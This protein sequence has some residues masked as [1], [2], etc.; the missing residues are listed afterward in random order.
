MNLRSLVGPR[1]EAIQ[2][3]IANMPERWRRFLGA[4]EEAAELLERLLRVGRL[5]PC[6][7]ITGRRRETS[8]RGRR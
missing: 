1:T 8:E 4:N 5:G 2:E 7:K 6:P 3:D